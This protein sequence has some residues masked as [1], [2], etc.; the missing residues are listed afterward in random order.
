MAGANGTFLF[1]LVERVDRF[2]EKYMFAALPFFNAVLFVREEPL[3]DDG[4]RRWRAELKPYRPQAEGS[5]A[6]NAN[7]GEAAHW[8]EV[9]KRLDRRGKR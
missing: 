8:P 1:T 6:T 4:V 7:D 5:N 2:D 9:S 3:G